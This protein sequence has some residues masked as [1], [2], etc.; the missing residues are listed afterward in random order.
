MVTLMLLVQGPQLEQGGYE[1]YSRERKYFSD[2]DRFFFFFEIQMLYAFI[3][4]N[5]TFKAKCRHSL[6]VKLT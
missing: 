6:D 3:L 1:V 2:D 5:R 4:L